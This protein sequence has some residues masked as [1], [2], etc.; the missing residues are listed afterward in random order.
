LYSV[1]VAI[2]VTLGVLSE[3]DGVESLIVVVDKEISEQECFEYQFNRIAR[4]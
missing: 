1:G 3:E 4:G 2:D